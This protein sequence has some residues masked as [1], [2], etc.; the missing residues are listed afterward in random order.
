MTVTL[1]PAPTRTSPR[2]APPETPRRVPT[3]RP[4]PPAPVGVQARGRVAL[5]DP[6]VLADPGGLAVRVVPAVLAGP[7]RGGRADLVDPADPGAPGPRAR[8]HAAG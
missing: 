5:V 3:N 1:S 6:A 8:G 2:A 7:A 4:T